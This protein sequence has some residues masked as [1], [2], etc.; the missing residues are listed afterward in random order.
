MDSITGSI[1]APPLEHGEPIIAAAPCAAG[2][3]IF[4]CGNSRAQIWDGADGTVI[5]K[6]F[7]GSARIISGSVDPGGQRIAASVNQVG[8]VIWDCSAGAELCRIGGNAVRC[9]FS[10]QGTA[11]L[12]VREDGAQ[13]FDPNT[14]A[15]LSPFVAEP[16]KS[17]DAHFSPDSRRVLQW[18][19]TTRAGQN[20]ARIWNATTGAV[21]TTLEAHWRAI[22]EAVF[23]PDGRL[24]ASGGE[25]HVLRI[26]DSVSGKPVFPPR[27]HRN[28]V[29]KVGFSPD[30]SFVWAVSDN[31]V[32]VWDTAA[33]ELVGPRLRHP[34]D[35]VA[36]AWSADS[37]RF[38]TI[39]DS[40]SPRL[41][42]FVPDSRSPEELAIIARGLSAHELSAG[43]SD[44]DELDLE[45]SCAAWRHMGVMD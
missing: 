9:E 27:R 1:V 34:K 24:V 8:V 17:T 29:R 37:Q 44:L 41:W 18:S 31:D 2:R 16:D 14:G 23:S 42:N 12:V 21:E 36:F 7:V 26:C 19:R 35:P 39:G 5:G 32:L 22:D 28:Q 6:A 13:V 15:A 10:P 3:R 20:A 25:D 43:T 30:S 45:E 38:V 33:A 4:T 11:L 40:F